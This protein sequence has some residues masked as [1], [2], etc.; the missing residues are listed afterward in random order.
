MLMVYCDVL[1][2]N[3]CHSLWDVL[4]QAYLLRSCPRSLR[5]LW[6]FALA[7]VRPVRASLWLAFIFC[8]ICSV[9]GRRFLC[10]PAF[11]VVDSLSS[12]QVDF[13]PFLTIRL[14]AQINSYQRRMLGLLLIK[15]L[16]QRPHTKQAKT[17]ATDQQSRTAVASTWRCP[18]SR[19]E[20]SVLLRCVE[21]NYEVGVDCDWLLEFSPD[22]MPTCLLTGYSACF[23]GLVLL[24]LTTLQA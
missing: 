24:G 15:T 2:T 8:D 6:Q 7:A 19:E 11:D 14:L 16:L 21:D 17:A 13:S 3:C 9:L 5:W 4:A 12:I 18:V 10:F 22:C 23:T 1:D 20:L